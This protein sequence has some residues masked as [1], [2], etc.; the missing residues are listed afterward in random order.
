MYMYISA[1]MYMYLPVYFPV[2]DHDY[3]FVTL[4]LQAEEIRFEL[5]RR[6]FTKIFVRRY[7][8]QHEESRKCSFSVFGHFLSHGTCY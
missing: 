7:S 3:A 6:Y 8:A 4:S 5:V 2:H 1:C